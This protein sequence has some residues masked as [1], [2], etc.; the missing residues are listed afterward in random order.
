MPLSPRFSSLGHCG[1]ELSTPNPLLCTPVHHCA[2]YDTPFCPDCVR[3]IRENTQRVW[4]VWG[5]NNRA[6]WGVET[7]MRRGENVPSPSPTCLLSEF[8]T[9]SILCHV[10]LE[11]FAY[12]PRSGGHFALSGFRSPPSPLYLVCWMLYCPLRPHTF[13]P[14]HLST[15]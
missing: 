11:V 13:C 3:R 9:S 15:F 12:S 8:P 7:K 6:C 10:F 2:Y 4:R 5:E 1:R 14:T